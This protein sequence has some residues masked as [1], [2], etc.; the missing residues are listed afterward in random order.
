VNIPPTALVIYKMTHAPRL[1]Y[2]RSGTISLICLV[3]LHYRLSSSGS[4]QFKCALPIFCLIIHNQ[5]PSLSQP[6]SRR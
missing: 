5:L 6:R 4:G 3:L 2:D 1:S